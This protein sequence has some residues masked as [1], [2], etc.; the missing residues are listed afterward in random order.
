[1]RNPAFSASARASCHDR[2]DLDRQVAELAQPR[3]DRLAQRRRGGEGADGQRPEL[4]GETA[5]D[6]LARPHRVATGVGVQGGELRCRQRCA[7]NGAR[8]LVE[9]GE[10]HPGQLEGIGRGEFPG[11]RV[12]RRGRPTR[13]D[14]E[15]REMTGAAPRPMQHELG[16]GID[17]LGVVD[18]QHDRAVGGQ[19]GE[20]RLHRHRDRQRRQRDLRGARTERHPQ[21]HPVFLPQRGGLPIDGRQHIPERV[22]GDLPLRIRRVHAEHPVAGRA[23]GRRGLPQDRRLA[24][25]W[26]RD[27]QDTPRRTGR[28]I[29]DLSEDV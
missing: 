29:G 12:L 7:D 21:E 23:E 26:L 8:Q 22:V 6:E 5:G 16:F 27:Q 4:G 13:R 15:H 3:I 20:Q 2:H 18:Q 11:R 1:M 17:P 24:H 19:V 28:D 10:G 25:P 9:F 14:D